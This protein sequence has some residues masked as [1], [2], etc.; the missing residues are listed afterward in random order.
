MTPRIDEITEQR[1]Q[2]VERLRARNVEPYPH[3]YHR[4]HT[5]EQAMSLLKEQN[6]LDG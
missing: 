5:T 2:K 4:S 3:R 1:L 6:L